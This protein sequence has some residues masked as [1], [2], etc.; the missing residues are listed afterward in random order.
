M[1]HYT[2][3]QKTR[4]IG[5]MPC[6]YCQLNLLTP[7]THDWTP[8]VWHQPR[9]LYITINP[10]VEQWLQRKCHIAYCGFWGKL[11]GMLGHKKRSSMTCLAVCGKCF[12]RPSVCL[13]GFFFFL[14]PAISRNVTSGSPKILSHR[15]IYRVLSNKWINV[16]EW[17]RE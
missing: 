7:I 2:R 11:V 4:T 3:R 1:S 10:V 14:W 13:S 8:T 5:R 17:V 16:G 12:I 15:V 6:Q 9:T